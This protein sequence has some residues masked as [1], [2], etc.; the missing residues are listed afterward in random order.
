MG[1]VL[2]FLAGGLKS[3][4]GMAKR[5]NTVETVRLAIELLRR[6]PRI[7][8]VTAAE[9][10]RQLADAGIDRDLRTIQRQLKLL[11]EHFDIERGERGL[12][13]GYRWLKGGAALELPQMTSQQPL[14]NLRQY[15]NDGFFGLGE[16][17]RMRLSFRI[18]RNAGAHLLETPL[19]MDR[20]V[21]DDEGDVLKV[22]ATVVDSSMLQRW[23]REFADEIGEISKSGIDE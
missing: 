16:E 14:F 2:R 6:I 13:Y 21:S 3:A 12:T 4:P 7:G 10:H 15:V 20:H 9:L 18:S 1:Q 23:L 17:Q 8:M 11:S 19:S 5:S 22:T